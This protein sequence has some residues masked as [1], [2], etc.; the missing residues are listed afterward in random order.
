MSRDSSTFVRHPCWGTACPYSVAHLE[1]ALSHLASVRTVFAQKALRSVKTFWSLAVAAPGPRRPVTD[2]EM[3]SHLRILT[4]IAEAA[5]DNDMSPASAV[6]PRHVADLSLRTDAPI[7]DPDRW[8]DNSTGPASPSMPWACPGVVVTRP[9]TPNQCF[10]VFCRDSSCMMSA[11]SNVQLV[12]AIV[13]MD[14]APVAV[15][16]ATRSREQF[17]PGAVDSAFCADHHRKRRLLQDFRVPRTLLTVGR[18]FLV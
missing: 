15:M 9:A 5:P 12:P 17:A 6:G 11:A 8:P 3:I 10:V 7:Q 14:C 16:S 18:V 13:Q 2:H 1:Q 4:S